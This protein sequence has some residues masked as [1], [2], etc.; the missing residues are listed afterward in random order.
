MAQALQRLCKT[1]QDSA[2]TALT[3]FAAFRFVVGRAFAEFEL[4]GAWVPGCLGVLHL[5]T[6][7]PAGHGLQT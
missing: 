4:W 2:V 5:R 1:L 6:L 3:A 7:E